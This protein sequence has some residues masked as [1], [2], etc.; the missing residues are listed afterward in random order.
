[1][2]LL[3]VGGGST[4]FILG[5]GDEKHFAESFPLGTVRLMETISHSDPPTHEEFSRCRDWLKNFL[6][7]EIR[8]KLQPALEREKKSGAIQLAGT[9]GTATLL[10]KMELKMVKFD[11]EKIEATHLQF[12]QIQSHRQKLWRLPL[13]ERKEI[14]RGRYSPRHI[15][16][17]IGDGRIWFH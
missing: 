17:R 8:P 16:L 15:D 9:G 5:H 12:K 6:K 13:A 10:A 4:E 2:L 3:D 1:L 11:R 7:K 14:A